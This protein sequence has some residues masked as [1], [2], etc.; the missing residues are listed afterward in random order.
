[1]NRPASAPVAHP[2]RGSF[3]VPPFVQRTTRRI[4]LLI[5]LLVLRLS[6]TSIRFARLSDGI[7]RRALARGWQDAPVNGDATMYAGTESGT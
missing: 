2:R 3:F 1:M 5:E 6:A 4:T 7:S